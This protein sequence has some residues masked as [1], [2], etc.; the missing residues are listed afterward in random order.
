MS[1]TS[2][3]QLAAIVAM[4]T[5]ISASAGGLIVLLVKFLT[6][7]KYEIGSMCNGI[8]A[9]LVAITAGCGNVES[10]SAFVIGIVGGLVFFAA[11]TLLVRLKVDDPLDAFA[12]HG[13]A[14]A[15]GVLAAALFDWGKGFDRYNGFGG[16][17][18]NA[19]NANDGK[20][21]GQWAHGFAAAIVEV[22]V[23]M[24]WSGGVSTVVF[25]P[26]RLLGL[27][28]ADDESQDMGMDVAKHSPSKAYAA[29]EVPIASRPKGNAQDLDVAK[30]S[31][32]NDQAVERI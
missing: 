4:N 11:S 32:G 3:G 5:T 1:S 14:G 13:A 25:L 30:P 9:G 15:W 23:I 19:A 7:K 26:L 6:T 2:V 17:L 28:R 29:E 20:T 27:L 21:E 10:G 24:L 12:V 16:G 18:G 31:E 8:L 22:L